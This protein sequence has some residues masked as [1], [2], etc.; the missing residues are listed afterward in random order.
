[1]EDNT[2]YN[3]QAIFDTL[4]NDPNDTT[5]HTF[6]Y[7]LD[8]INSLLNDLPNIEVVSE[9]HVPSIKVESFSPLSNDTSI[10]PPSNDTV[11]ESSSRSSNSFCEDLDFS[12]QMV[13]DIVPKKPNNNEKSKVL[14]PICKEGDAGRHKH[15]GGI[16]CISCRAFF[17]RSVQNDAYKKFNC[18]NQLQNTSTGLLSCDINSKS[19]NSCR[20]CRFHK[21]LSSGLKVS[22]VLKSNAKSGS[23]LD[24]NNS[25]QQYQGYEKT[26]AQRMNSVSRNV[27]SSASFMNQ[28]VMLISF[29]VSQYQFEYLRQDMTRFFV[30]HP[31]NFDTLMNMYFRKQ[32]TPGLVDI[33]N[34]QVFGK[35]WQNHFCSYLSTHN[36]EHNAIDNETTEILYN[37]NMA[38][39][40]FLN[41][42]ISIGNAIC[43][44][45]LRDILDQVYERQRYL[46]HCLPHYMEDDD[47]NYI[48]HSPTLDNN[49]SNDH[50]ITLLAKHATR[51]NVKVKPPERAIDYNQAYPA[52]MWNDETR[53]WEIIIRRNIHAV[54][55]W[56]TVNENTIHSDEQ[57]KKSRNKTQKK[58][59]MLNGSFCDKNVRKESNGT[60]VNVDYVLVHLLSLI[61]LYSTDTCTGLKNTRPIEN[62]QNRYL[63][64]LHQYLTFRYP[65]DA[66]IRL[67]RGMDIMSKARECCEI[68]QLLS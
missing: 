16:A 10:P 1:M 60:I 40:Y 36:A 9:G 32:T 5:Q 45:P 3:D 38:A 56:P 17:R 48:N 47:Q 25:N 28:E 54:A 2:N 11:Y 55:R 8:L 66:Y 64:L 42:V 52:E 21:C 58:S 6:V 46:S 63:H 67:A 31:A 14:C 12:N 7:D 44:S 26:I 61:T 22:L 33:G 43:P 65:K 13:K 37:F 15:Y 41:S 51:Q 29:N 49:N 20:Y 19:W 53:K 24:R 50:L 4:L 68:L 34:A 59:I 62:L 35:W 57:N 39:V 18:P 23:Q 30:E 27:L